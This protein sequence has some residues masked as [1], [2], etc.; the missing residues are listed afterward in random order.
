MTEPSVPPATPLADLLLHPIR[1]RIIQRVLGREVTTTDLRQDLPDVAATT[2]YRHVAALI[3]GGVLTVVRERRIR[4]AVERTLTLDQSTD[5]AH[6]EDAEARAMTPDQHRRGLL[7]MLT[8][9]TADYDRVVEHG[10]LD[11]RHEQFGFNQVSLYVDSDDLDTL[12][13]GLQTLVEP[14]LRAA[15]GKDRITLSTVS[16]PDT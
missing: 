6:I 14:Y 9:L 13:R 2:L 4:G 10:Y 15:P 7:L 1:W 5:V 12:R 16:L 8:Q 11:S 3:D